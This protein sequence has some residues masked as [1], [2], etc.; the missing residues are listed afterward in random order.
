MKRRIVLLLMFV[1]L[2]A[3]CTPHSESTRGSEDS[4]PQFP[5]PLEKDF[6]VCVGK[7]DKIFHSNFTL[8]DSTRF[9]LMTREPITEEDITVKTGDISWW[10]T[11]SEI[12]S[13]AEL[14]WRHAHMMCKDTDWEAVYQSRLQSAESW[15]AFIEQNAAEA[16]PVPE[17]WFSGYHCYLVIIGGALDYASTV[18]DGHTETDLTVTVKGSTQVLEDVCNIR[19]YNELGQL[20]NHQGPMIL[21]K[22]NIP[23]AYIQPTEDGYFYSSE[24]MEFLARDEDVTIT[25][26]SFLNSPSA[27]FV[28]MQL[29]VEGVWME[30][31]GKTPVDVMAGEHVQLR[32]AA[33][34]PALTG[35]V[36]NSCNRIVLLWY[37]SGGES[38]VLG[39]DNKYS[40]LLTFDEYYTFAAGYGDVVYE[41]YCEYLSKI[42]GWEYGYPPYPGVEGSSSD[43]PFYGNYGR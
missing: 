26:V 8:Y 12:D 5:I 15:G 29:S 27:S 10:V 42:T 9:G 33:K 20:P 14:E 39:A 28:R 36:V 17:D 7:I 40:M 21:S 4:K 24:Y 18:E 19:F 3:G 6:Y 37:T 41:R 13:G 25:G 1:L 16:G 35:A 23:G 34:D 31:D 38:Y 11:L 2:L 43:N 22:L 30:W 32:F